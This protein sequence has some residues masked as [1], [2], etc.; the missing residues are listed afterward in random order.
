MGKGDS[1]YFIGVAE[2]LTQLP[3]VV[4]ERTGCFVWRAM[5]E[6]SNNLSSDGP[7]IFAA[8]GSSEI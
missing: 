7:D 6:M 2:L 5:L 3:T 1:E 4:I 8:A